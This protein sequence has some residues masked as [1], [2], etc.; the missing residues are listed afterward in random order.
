M[1]RQICRSVVRIFSRVHDTNFP[2]RII[3]YLQNIRTTSRTNL[4]GTFFRTMDHTK[5]CCPEPLITDHHRYWVLV[6]FGH[7]WIWDGLSNRFCNLEHWFAHGQNGQFHDQCSAT[8]YC[9]STTNHKS[10]LKSTS[11]F[12]V[13]LSD[14]LDG[15]SNWHFESVLWLAVALSVVTSLA[16]SAI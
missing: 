5:I 15:V 10:P 2:D 12:W 6:L 14:H 7:L 11:S 13:Y 3:W 1:P 9:F 8:N 4:S 16:E